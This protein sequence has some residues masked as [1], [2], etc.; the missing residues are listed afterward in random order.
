[1]KAIIFLSHIVLYLLQTYCTDQMTPDSAA[2]STAYHCGVKTKMDT[3]G[4]D[5]SV[6][7]NDCSTVKAAKVKSVLDFAL[8]EGEYHYV[9]E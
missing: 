6:I 1:M 2:T 3:L 8:A 7:R 4:V 5:D 9:L